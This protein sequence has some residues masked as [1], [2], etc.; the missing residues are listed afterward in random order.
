MNLNN[1]DVF[2]RLTILSFSHKNSNR[3]QFYLCRCLCGKNT[4]VNKYYLTSGKTKSCGCLS[5]DTK[6]ARKLSDNMASINRILHIYQNHAKERNLNFSLEKK[7][8]IALVKSSCYYCGMKPSNRFKNN[9][10]IFHYSGIDRMDSS[11]GY[12]LDNCVAACYCCNLAKMEMSKIEFIQ[13]A[14]RV[15]NFFI[16]KIT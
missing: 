2:N 8:F 7:D 14:K 4:V 12:T 1:G 5:T 13:W 16:K 3:K 11:L 10:E 9:K 15:Y 6:K